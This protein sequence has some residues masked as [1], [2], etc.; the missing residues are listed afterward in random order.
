M[1]RI[2]KWDCIKLKII[3]TAKEAITRMKRQPIVWERL[4]GR[5]SSNRELI[6]R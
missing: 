3:C 1:A 6:S 5:Y 2:D 4:F